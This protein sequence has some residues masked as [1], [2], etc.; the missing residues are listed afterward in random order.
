MASLLITEEITPGKEI[1]EGILHGY[2]AKIREKAFSKT[3][4]ND[5]SFG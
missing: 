4:M 1:Q 2:I 5:I 3:E